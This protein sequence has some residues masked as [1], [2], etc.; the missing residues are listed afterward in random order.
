MPESEGEIKVPKQSGV[1]IP[2]EVQ[3]TIDLAASVEALVGTLLQWG[4]IPHDWLKQDLETVRRVR[5]RLEA[6][7]ARTTEPS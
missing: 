6:S 4:H 5:E 7:I 3:A 2:V 1:A